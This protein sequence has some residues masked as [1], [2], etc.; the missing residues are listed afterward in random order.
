MA[1]QKQRC[2]STLV[3]AF[4]ASQGEP[5]WAGQLTSVP[6]YCRKKVHRRPDLTWRQFLQRLPSEKDLVHAYVELWIRQYGSWC[7]TSDRV[8]E[9][10]TQIDDFDVVLAVDTSRNWYH[11][12][13]KALGEELR[14]LSDQY[15]KVVFLGVS[16][17]GNAAL[18]YAYLADLVLVFAAQMDL[19]ISELRPGFDSSTIDKL[20]ADLRA[21]VFQAEANGCKIM[22]H[23]G[24]DNYLVESKRLPIADGRDI[25]VHP[26]ACGR[27]ANALHYAD[28]LRPILQEA[29]LIAQS[30]PR[31]LR[32]APRTD[33]GRLAEATFRWDA[34]SLVRWEEAQCVIGSISPADLYHLASV[35]LARMGYIPT[36]G[37]WFCDL[38]HCPR[39]SRDVRCRRHHDREVLAP[40]IGLVG[41]RTEHKL[42]DWNCGDCRRILRATTPQCACGMR[43]RKEFRLRGWC[44]ECWQD[45]SSENYKRWKSKLYCG[46]CFASWERGFY[47]KRRRGDEAAAAAAAATNGSKVIMTNG[48]QSDSDNL[49]E[50]ASKEASC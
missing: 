18:R 35:L 22:V 41:L 20:N 27:L 43:Y 26:L 25:H 3:V 4:A 15:A 24:L 14:D 31:A 34:L 12:D 23:I 19:S 45:V 21:S 32:Q 44:F 29:I 8:T 42:G 17:G 30:R 16:M 46:S 38:C 1:E 13:G 9:E 37:D 39:Q 7:D 2:R 36:L 49:S 40:W 33:P 11:K 6:G 5:E 47:R 28:I 48:K 50:G 10:D